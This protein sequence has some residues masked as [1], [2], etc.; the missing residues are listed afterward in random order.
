[1]TDA[2]SSRRGNH[3]RRDR[4]KVNRMD[5]TISRAKALNLVKDVCDAILSGCGSHYDGE[6]EVYDNPLEVDAILKCNKEI[7]TALKHLPSAQPTMYGYDIKTLAFVAGVM[8]QEGVTPEE[9][10]AAFRDIQKCVDYIW[11]DV[12]KTI[13]KS[14][15]DVMNHDCSTCLHSDRMPHIY[16]CD[17]CSTGHEGWERKI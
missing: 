7:R 6:D 4:G 11:S 5:D 10:V 14:M 8:A 9:A 16:P 1:M 13:Q 12:H 15:D 17:K 2:I 3:S